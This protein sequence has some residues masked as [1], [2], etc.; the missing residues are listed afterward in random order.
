MMHPGLQMKLLE[1]SGSGRIRG[2]QGKG[3]FSLTGILGREEVLTT[4][5]VWTDLPNLLTS[6]RPEDK[7]AER[8]ER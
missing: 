5:S 3:L 4:S 7:K 1:P 8:M 6:V 2:V